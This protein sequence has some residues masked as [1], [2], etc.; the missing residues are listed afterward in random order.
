VLVVQDGRQVVNG[1][2]K[3]RIVEERDKHG[4]HPWSCVSTRPTL[5]HNQHVLLKYH[6]PNMY[7]TL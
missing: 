7:E 1:P 6:T 3:D 2:D 5:I 4:V